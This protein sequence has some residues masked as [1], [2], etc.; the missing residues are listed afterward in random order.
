MRTAINGI[1]VSGITVAIPSNV[2]SVKDDLPDCDPAE[3]QKII[4]V[5]GVVERRVLNDSL[6]ASDMCLFAAN[7]LLN[8]LGWDRKTIGPL[9]FVTQ[10][11]DY[12]LPATACILQTKL[13]IGQECAAFDVN[14][15]CSGFVYGYWL[16]CSLL[17]NS[18]AKRGLLLCGDT[19]TRHLL[20]NDRSTISLFGDAGAAIA[21]EI[22]ETASLTFFNVGTD[23]T[24]AKN[25][26]VEAGGR[27]NPI[28]KSPNA[29][30]AEE[31]RIGYENSRLR[32]NGGEIFSFSLK[33]VA[34]LV[35]D[36]LNMSELTKEAIDYYVLHQANK[37]ML[38][39]IRRKIGIDESKFIENLRHYGNTSSASIPLA[40]C[41]SLARTIK[42]RRSRIM[43]VGFGVGWSWGGMIIDIGPE[44]IVDLI[45]IP[46]NHEAIKL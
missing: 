13:G 27:R 46:I 28:I 24:G 4:D 36:L 42:K 7:E 14:L 31:A 19:S 5:T 39:K 3:L 11:P 33:K 29:L 41:D 15:G 30:Q 40:I 43:C 35:E 25:I 32:L 45:Q 37:F 10:D 22:S 26:I 44:I 23:G 6:C 38:E 18:D 8:R 21:I 12:S 20:P 17:Q 16:L 34:P 9:I 2:R 1:S